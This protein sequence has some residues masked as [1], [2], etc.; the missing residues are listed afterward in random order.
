MTINRVKGTRDFYPEDWAH[1]RWLSNQLI[2][3]G[4]LFGYEEFE[5]PILEPIELYLDKT[6][7][8]IVNKQ[9]FG[10]TDR[11]GKSLVMRPELTPSLARMVAEREGQLT[12]PIRWQSYGQFFRYERPQRGRGRAFYQWN[13]DFLGLDSPLADAEVLE[14]A[15][16]AFKALDLPPE[17]IEVRLNDRQAL[18]HFLTAELG[19]SEEAVA[20]TLGLIDRR[21]KMG[22]E[23]FVAALTDSGLPASQ[24]GEVEDALSRHQRI[25]SPWLDEIMELLAARGV[26]DY[27][28][29]D[30]TIV[31]GF[32][33]YTSTV[34]EM[35]ANT[36]LRRALGGGGRY[37][38]L[39]VQVGG[40]QTIPGVGFA[41]GE[42][43]L[44]E[45][46]DEIGRDPSGATRPATLFVSVFS[47]DLLPA[48]TDLAN[49]VRAAGIATELS[50]NP[51]QRLDRQFRYA[52]RKKIPYVAVLGP[53]EATKGQVTLKNLKD[54]TQQTVAPDVLVDALKGQD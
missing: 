53:D 8:E 15:C 19:I 2:S 38:N 13:L 26:E 37:A 22:S 9:T 20:T 32:D 36:T 5:G 28:K 1:Q 41:L 42:M 18:D 52:D 40:R 11:D 44:G 47:D 46:F 39:T 29:L 43:P 12:F 24:A 48:S 27:V 23:K 50:T 49:R 35:W 31:R 34:F 4:R 6:S 21:D 30:L 25:V 45:L 3:V 7:E 16:R 33:Y 14:I 10:L 51:G 54:G 17:L